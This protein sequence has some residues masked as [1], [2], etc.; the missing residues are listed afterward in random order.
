VVNKLKFKEIVGLKKNGIKTPR[1]DKLFE[2]GASF[3]HSL[4]AP[5]T[6]GMLD[7]GS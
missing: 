6:P 3:L 1:E 7:G 5:Y 2:I 4:K